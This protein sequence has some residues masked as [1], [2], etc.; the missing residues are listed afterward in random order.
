MYLATVWTKDRQKREGIYHLLP[1]KKSTRGRRSTINSKE[2]SGPIPREV[3]RESQFGKKLDE[4][5]FLGEENVSSKW[6]SYKG[7]YTAR[8][9]KLLVAK[10]IQS[11]I[12]ISFKNHIYWYHGELFK[13]IRGGA[14]GAR[15][16]GVVARIVMDKWEEKLR[17]SIEKKLGQDLIIWEIHR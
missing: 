4:D 11:G 10:C 3:A 1:R 7:Y 5:E 8:D 14:I 15:L 6:D 13:Q 17:V 12:E 9:K 2:L 16:T